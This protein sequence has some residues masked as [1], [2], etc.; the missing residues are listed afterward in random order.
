MA[1][2]A[3]ES[4]N[5]RT[6]LMMLAVAA[7]MLALGFAAV[8]LYRIFCQVT[9]FGGTTQRATE[10]QADA[11]AANSAGALEFGFFLGGHAAFPT[12]KTRWSATSAAKSAKR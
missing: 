4:R 6:G 5:R 11:A 3:L 2:V 8:P 1:S 12:P 9:G 10:A 7:A